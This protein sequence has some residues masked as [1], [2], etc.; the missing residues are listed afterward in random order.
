MILG[1]DV[2]GTLTKMA[3]GDGSDLLFEPSEFSNVFDGY[4]TPIVTT[5][6][7][8]IESL[9]ENTHYRIHG[10]A[11]S[12][13]G[14]IDADNGTVIGSN[15]TIPGYEGTRFKEELEKKFR[16]TTEVMNDANAA[17]LG[18]CVLG[19]GYG[20]RNGIMITVGTGIGCGIVIDGKEYCGSKGIAGEFGQ[21]F[22]NAVDFANNRCYE[23]KASTAAL[24]RMCADILPCGESEL[25]GRIIFK[26]AADGDENVLE[27]IDHWIS[28]VALGL[29]NLT[30]IFNPEILII[31]GGVSTQKE[32]FIEPLRKKVLSG[33][34][35]SFAKGLRIEPAILGN[36][37]GIHGA[38]LNFLRKH[39][40]GI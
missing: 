31:G 8:H 38:I 34:H 21:C 35:P 5:V 29:I 12:A 36:T 37:A 23:T 27:V 39:A 3:V 15:G 10:I 30:F 26:K 1:I 28:D 32:L 4:R 14:Q 2:G 9:L 18:E 11:I 17:A 40:A 24:V 19:A 6:E 13:T 16:L 33:L 7:N 25:N 22:F 20:A